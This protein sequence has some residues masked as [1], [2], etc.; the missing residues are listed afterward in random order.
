[1]LET[2]VGLSIEKVTVLGLD[3]SGGASALEVNG[4]SVR[5][6]FFKHKVECIGA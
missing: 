6:K 5:D 2:K 4:N 3:G 1:M